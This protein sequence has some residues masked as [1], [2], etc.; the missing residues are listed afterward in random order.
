MNG[1]VSVNNKNELEDY[2]LIYPNNKKLKV[3][4]SDGLT[5]AKLRLGTTIVNDL[6]F[7]EKLFNFNNLF[8]TKY[9]YRNFIDSR[10]ISNRRLS[11]QFLSN[12]DKLVQ[13]FYMNHIKIVNSQFQ[14]IEV[15]HIS[16]IKEIYFN[17]EMKSVIIIIDE[18]F[19]SSQE[20][21]TLATKRKEENKMRNE[22]AKKKTLLKEVND[23][24]N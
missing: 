5:T 10:N 18:K 11:L 24:L 21:K 12:E 23:L 15:A 3:N 4:I 14:K 13:I 7:F 19:C 17:D 16:K 9:D 6:N 22:E 1:I 8:I 2:K 20:R